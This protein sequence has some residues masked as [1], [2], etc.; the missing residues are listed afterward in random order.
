MDTNAESSGY[1]VWA[2]DNIVYGPV[3]LP[4]LITWIKE[5]RVFGKTWLYADKDK[6]WHKADALPELQMFFKDKP[7]S[8]STGN[9]RVSRIAGIVEPASLRRIKILSTLD[10]EQLARFLEFLEVQSVN[11]F[12]RVI[13]QGDPGDAMY[14]I[15]EGEV[16]VRLLINDR[17]TTLATLSVG[18]FFGEMALFDQSPR[19]ADVI[20]NVD[21]TVLKI[22]VAMF[23]KLATAAPDL[24]APFLMG[25]GR[26]LAARIRSDNKRLKETISLSRAS[27]SDVVGI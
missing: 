21:S 6:K 12:E 9:N 4:T 8:A 16:R 25:M 2:V 11:Q 23:H 3:E 27:L 7:S 14:L 24:A 15:L 10:D 20:A 17:E 22:S 1:R 13:K 26:T 5:E 19:S 18:E